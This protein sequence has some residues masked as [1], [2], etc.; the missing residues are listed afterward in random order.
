MTKLCKSVHIRGNIAWQMRSGRSE[1]KAIKRQKAIECLLINHFTLLHSPPP[2]CENDFCVESTP[3]APFKSIIFHQSSPAWTLFFCLCFR[4]LPPLKC[5]HIGPQ[6]IFHH[7]SQYAHSYF[8]LSV[9]SHVWVKNHVR[10]RETGDCLHKLK[11]HISF[12]PK[13]WQNSLPKDDTKNIITLLSMELLRVKSDCPIHERVFSA[14]T[15]EVNNAG[16]VFSFSS[17]CSVIAELLQ[18]NESRNP[19][20]FNYYAHN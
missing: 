9:G 3:V 1:R 8:L 18:R 7:F 5:I 2:S 15:I 11:L 17:L 14:F 20:V 13:S 6:T 19:Q 4:N 12:K 16:N 10:G